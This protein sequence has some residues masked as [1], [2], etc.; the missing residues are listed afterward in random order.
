MTA[1]ETRQFTPLAVPFA[2]SRGDRIAT[3]RY[4][5][6]E[7]FAMEEELLWSRVWQ[8]AA[9]LAE[10]PNAGD[11]VEYQLLDKSVILVRQTDGSVKAFHNACRHRGVQLLEGRGNIGGGIIC[12]FHSW[13]Y[14]PDGVNTFVYQPDAF[15]E[16][17][18]CPDHVN[19]KPCRVETWGGCAFVNFDDAAPPLRECLEPFATWGDAWR[20]DSLYPEWWLSC[21]MPANWKT[22]MEAFMEGYHAMQTHP[23]LFPGGFAKSYRQEGEGRLS[24]ERLAKLLNG[25]RD[26]FDRQSF[27][28]RQLH[29]L[30]TL[31]TGMGGMVHENDVRLAEGLADIELPNEFS[32]AIRSWT[33]A[34]NDT[35]TNWHRERGADCPDLNQ[36]AA[37]GIIGS[38]TFCFPNFFMLPMYSSASS[39]RIRPLGPEECLFELWSLTRYPEGAAPPAPITPEPMAPDDPRWPEIPGQDFSNIP[40]QQQGLHAGGFDFMRLSERLEGI[41]GNYHRLVDGFLARLPYE[42]LVPA[43]HKVCGSFECEVRDLGF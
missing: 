43:M 28:E 31:S 1:M 8:M 23:Q 27:V 5:D 40:R 19:L 9:R 22:A 12:P 39:Y 30:R 18:R 13:S 21:R 35:V 33:S 4:F 41:V 36:L 10:I 16:S 25:G 42:K 14:G 2:M 7:F 32:G 37:K 34:L 17:N 26:D 20:F 6:P 15:A 3:G 24:P 38:T 11:F 29:H